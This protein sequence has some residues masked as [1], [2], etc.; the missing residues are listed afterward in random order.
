MAPWACH[1]GGRAAES[2]DVGRRT[3]RAYGPGTYHRGYEKGRLDYP[4]GYV[5]WTERRNLAEFIRLVGQGAVDPEPL[6]AGTY[7]IDK[8]QDAF[9]AI[10]E[11]TLDGVAALIDYEAEKQEPDRRKTLEIR[12]RPKSDQ[13]LGI[14]IIGCG[15]HALA[16]HL[17]NLRSMSEIE[18]RG[19]A[20]ATGVNATLVGKN[21]GA[22]IVTTDV[23]EVLKDAGTDAVIISSSQQ[24]PNPN[25]P[26]RFASSLTKPG[27]SPESP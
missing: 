7:T 10:R 14:S 2:R 16:T 5:R 9:D 4:F 20:S 15:N 19:L 1:D 6:I 26:S 17:P 27:S 8:V 21:V 24:K 12:P 13:K 25:V 3:T 18:I 22:T 11:G 23:A